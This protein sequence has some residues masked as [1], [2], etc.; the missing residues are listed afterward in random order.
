[1]NAEA[2]F[3]TLVAIVLLIA[4]SGALVGRLR[5]YG[6]GRDRVARLR[7]DYL[8]RRKTPIGKKAHRP[9]L[10]RHLEDPLRQ[11]V[12]DLAPFVLN[13]L[14]LYALF[15]TGHYLALPLFVLPV[16][17]AEYWAVWKFQQSQLPAY[18]ADLDRYWHVLTDQNNRVFDGVVQGWNL[19]QKEDELAS[20][21]LLLGGK[22]V[23][24]TSQSRDGEL[25]VLRLFLPIQCPTRAPEDRTV[26][27][28]YLP[29]PDGKVQG[30]EAAGTIR[31]FQSIPWHP[32]FRPENGLT[33]DE[34]AKRRVVNW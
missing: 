6:F 21:H 8:V 24:V 15:R 20:E 27:V 22:I 14:V 29:S 32:L 33:Y 23:S 30:R 28:F 25:N 3:A 2:Y 34:Y 10:I 16:M 1:M 4:F 12:L 13:G 11:T 9:L 18:Q 17:A 26:R 31:D 7:A 5:H 19:D